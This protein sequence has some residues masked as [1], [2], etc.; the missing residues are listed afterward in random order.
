[1][2]M[3]HNP[4][5]GLD[6][7]SAGVVRKRPQLGQMSPR[8]RHEYVR[9]RDYHTDE[10]IYHSDALHHG[11]QREVQIYLGRYADIE[12]VET[13]D[14]TLILADGEIVGYIGEHPELKLMA[15]E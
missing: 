7:V 6:C 15:A 14:C 8:D 3:R 13:E 10:T 2:N 4:E 5:T 9:I 11:W 12:E 1:M